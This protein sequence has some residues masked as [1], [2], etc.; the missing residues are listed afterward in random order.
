MRVTGAA[1]AGAPSARCLSSASRLDMHDA[2]LRLCEH[3]GLSLDAYR[4]DDLR[5]LYRMAARRP[6]RLVA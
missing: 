3:N 5:P 1:G 6:L 2:V 4:F